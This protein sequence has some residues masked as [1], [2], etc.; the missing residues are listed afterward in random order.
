MRLGFAIH[1]GQLACAL[2]VLEYYLCNFSRVPE[3]CLSKFDFYLDT[4]SKVSQLCLGNLDLPSK[5]PRGFRTLCH[6]LQI[7]LQSAPSNECL[8]VVSV[9][10]QGFVETLHRVHI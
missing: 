4:F 5:L 1:Q 7:Y 2:E 8:H 9:D 10:L 3:F 6:T